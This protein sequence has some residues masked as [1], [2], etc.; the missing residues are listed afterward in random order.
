MG[1]TLSG[2]PTAQRPNGQTRWINWRTSI[3]HCHVAGLGV[4]VNSLEP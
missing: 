3:P 4:A 2:R 1:D